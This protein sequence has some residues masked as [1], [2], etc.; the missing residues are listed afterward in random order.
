MVQILT[1]LP[2]WNRSHS[3]PVPPV[4]HGV[5]NTDSAHGV[6]QMPASAGAGRAQHA[7]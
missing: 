4:R 2:R 3:R 1:P 7:L 6:S 5:S